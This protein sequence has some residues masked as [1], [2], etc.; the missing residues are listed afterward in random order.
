MSDTKKN[1]NSKRI[2]AFRKSVRKGGILAYQVNDYNAQ[3]CHAEP[4][5]FFESSRAVHLGAYGLVG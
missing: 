1:E 2:K 5:N 4:P 3:R